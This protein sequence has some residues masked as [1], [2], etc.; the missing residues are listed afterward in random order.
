MTASPS[1]ILI[2]VDVGRPIVKISEPRIGKGASFGAD[3][4]GDFVDQIIIKGGSR[5]DR[6]GKRRC[7]GERS[8]SP[9]E[10]DAW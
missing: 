8:P 3:D 10:S 1:G 5:G 9:I 2:R 6:V 7:V 4:I